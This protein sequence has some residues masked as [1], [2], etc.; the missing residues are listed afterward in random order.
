MARAVCV[1][2]A[3]VVSRSSRWGLS[4]RRT[5]WWSMW[6]A[7]SAGAVHLP[8]PCRSRQGS[9][10]SSQSKAAVQKTMAAM[11]SQWPSAPSDWTKRRNSLGQVRASKSA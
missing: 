8:W 2:V 10:R 3:D 11:P 7:T 1:A 4:G 9:V 6:A 5:A